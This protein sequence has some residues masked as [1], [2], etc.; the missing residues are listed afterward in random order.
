MPLLISRASRII[1][2]LVWLVVAQHH[3]NATIVNWTLSGTFTDS[4]SLSGTFSVDSANGKLTEWDITTSATYLL[5]GF[6][7]TNANSIFTQDFWRTGNLNS[8][9]LARTTPYA[10][11]YLNLSFEDSLSDPGVN[12]LRLGYYSSGSWECNNCSP[13]RLIQEG[14][15]VSA[16]L[17]SSVPEPETYSMLI[18]GLMA[19]F[20]ARKHNTGRK[21]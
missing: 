19:I 15:A 10:E 9:M 21:F 16:A 8:F 3:A 1:T 7:Y 5:N 12:K 18:I 6:H 4:A 20:A 14:E 11:P 17:I 13:W 2:L